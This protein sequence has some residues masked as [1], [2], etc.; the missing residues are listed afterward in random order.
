MVVTGAGNAGDAGVGMG[1]IIVA[2]VIVDGVGG[3]GWS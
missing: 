3:G 1:V 2:D